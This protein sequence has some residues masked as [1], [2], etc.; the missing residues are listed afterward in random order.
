MGYPAGLHDDGPVARLAGYRAYLVAL[1]LIWVLP[2]AL[3]LLLYL[4]LPDYNAS[5]Q[6]EGIGWGCTLTPADGIA[7]LALLAAP[8]LFVLG[9]LVC[10]VIF[11]V[12]YV[13]R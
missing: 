11:F 1:G 2:A 4:T 10:A 13:R 7:F 6:C 8:F 3:L 12:R 5:G 9:L